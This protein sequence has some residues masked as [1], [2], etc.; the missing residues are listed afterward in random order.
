MLRRPQEQLLTAVP[1]DRIYQFSGGL[2]RDLITLGRDAA[3]EAYV[4]NAEL[5]RDEDVA[6]AARQLGE[7]YLRG[8]G[9]QHH[10]LLQQL[11][12]GEGFDI[13]NPFAQE[14]LAARRVVEYS[15]TE[16]GVHPSLSWPWKR[17][18]MTGNPSPFQIAQ[19]V[20]LRG[21]TEHS[22]AVVLS[23]SPTQDVWS[24]SLTIELETLTSSSVRTIVQ[25]TLQIGDLRNALH[26]P[27]N[28]IAIVAAGNWTEADRTA[29]DINRSA[30]ERRGTI[31]LWMT[32]DQLGELADV[33]PN[34]RSFIGTSM[35]F[36]GPDGS[37]M[38]EADRSR[39]ISEPESHYLM[40]SE[41]MLRAAQA[42]QVLS[43]PQAIEWLIPLGRGD[44]IP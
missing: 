42:G 44:L 4:S 6:R 26:S 7:S 33:A 34:I 32:V 23:D 2:L 10:K 20:E 40:T 39:R 22:W 5:I 11:G 15:G 43:Q 18:L 38:T 1:I 41:Q 9:S 13:T 36:L 29:F 12:N 8:R 24:A 21:A 14:L 3:G 25:S 28:F 27:S 35:F 31:L 16:F 19:R 30:F 37:A 17:P